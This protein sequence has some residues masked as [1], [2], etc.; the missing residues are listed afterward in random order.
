M[1]PIY[2][3]LAAKKAQYSAPLASDLIEAKID[4]SKNN[5]TVKELETEFALM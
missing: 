2:S 3:T 5:I 1:S 4:C